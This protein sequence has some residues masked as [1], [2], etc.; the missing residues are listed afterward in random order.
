MAK[1]LLELNLSINDE[2]I[3][4]VEK[5]PGKTEIES[6]GEVRLPKGAIKNGY[7]KEPTILLEKLT[8]ILK[9][10]KI[11]ANTV[12]WVLNEQNAILREIEIQKADLEKLTVQEYVL[13]Q[14]GKTIHFPFESPIFNHFIKV[15]K[16]DSIIVTLFILD[17]QMLQ[18]YVDVFDRLKI[19]EMTYEIPALSLWRLYYVSDEKEEAEMTG[20]I[21]APSLVKRNENGEVEEEEEDD[22]DFYEED[23]EDG[24]MI[25]TVYDTLLS[26][27]IF[28]KK[29]PVF[30][31]MEDIEKPEYLYDTIDTYVS[32][33]S[34]YYKFN[35]N[36][37]KKEVTKVV[38]YNFTTKVT[39]AM[40]N[41]EMNKRIVGVDFEVFDL[42]KKSKYYKRLLPTGCYIPLA[43]SFYK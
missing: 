37:G 7:I 39:D 3:G 18:D 13:S 12:R 20:S 6:Y 31:M 8:S 43:A 5:E 41:E 34:S 38:I 42:G 30:S 29:F 21:V 4:F 17:E 1:N 14:V 23:L 2:V 19:K 10:F 26:L 22:D 32:R 36:Q 16:D 24:L 25:A 28:D 11:R 35:K 15:A 40:L 9:S 27:T 33:I